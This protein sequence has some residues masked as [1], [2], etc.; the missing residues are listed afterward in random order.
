[1]RILFLLLLIGTS[2]FAQPWK[3]VWITGPGESFNIWSAIPPEELTRYEVL[4]FRK[5]FDLSSKP[6]IL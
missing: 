5:T 4:K 2:S 3:A 6:A 1:M